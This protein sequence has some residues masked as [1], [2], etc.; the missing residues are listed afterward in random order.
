MKNNN[1][2]DTEFL[3]VAAFS[4]HLRILFLAIIIGVLGGYGA[5]LFRYGI[6]ALQFLFYRN[7]ADFL[8]FID[9]VPIYLRLGLPTLGGLIVGLLVKFGA[10]EAKGHG[11]PEVMEA[12]ALREGRIRKRVA[13]VKILA[14]FKEQDASCLHV[15]DGHGEMVGILSFRDI[16]RLGTADEPIPELTAVEIATR[17]VSVVT[18]TDNIRSALHLMGGKGVSQLPEGN[19]ANRSRVEGILRQKDILTA[20][21]KAVL[22]K[23]LDEQSCRRQHGTPYPYWMAH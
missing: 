23:E 12:V 2:H 11:V 9:N 14:A 19:A 22:R 20:Y 6:K 16:R 15:L 13:V 10:P 5:V 8:T 7:Q 1:S 4:R 17:E 18:P 3:K 21:D